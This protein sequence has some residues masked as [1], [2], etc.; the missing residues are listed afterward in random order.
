MSFV[1]DYLEHTKTYESPTSFWKWSAYATIAAVMR[2]NVYRK[3]GDSN[4]YPN[5]YVLF[6]AQSGA[7]K[8]APIN[9]AKSLIEAVN[10][11]KVIAGRTSIQAVLDE[12]AHT[13]TNNKTGRL[14]KGGAAI[15]VA[16]ELAAGIVGDPAAISILTD[17]YDLKTDFKHHLR[18]TGR[19]K[20]DRIVFN[21]L[22]ASNA[23]L[24]KEVYTQG[25]VNGGLLGRTFVIVPSEFRPP[26][27][28][29]DAVDNKES[30]EN[31]KAQLKKISELNGEIHI[32]DEARDE[33]NKWY[34]PYYT[35]LKSK[36][37]KSGV[38]S[39]LH[40]GV[41]KLSI[42]LA[43]NDNEMSI[44]RCHMELAITE[45][46]SLIPNYNTFIMTSGKST[47]AEAGALF[48]EEILAAPDYTI[49]TKNF[50]QKHWSN[51]DSDLLSKLV[52]TLET[53]GL[54]QSIASGGQMSFKLT[55]KAIET[56]EAKGRGKE[57]K[58]GV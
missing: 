55:N 31:L 34:K 56:M 33:Y 7:R 11:T 22:A 44:R 14:I 6:L 40:M 53:A 54:V 30:H 57:Q 48:F 29:L 51:V 18:S 4:T 20:I 15:L 43:A 49:S 16:G 21:M 17:I 10:N 24:L 3:Q 41:F 25:A 42:I 52:L 50:L 47:Q 2:D 26:N 23:D 28:L 13:E 36:G 58:G 39:R 37:D 35:S 5:I 38:L 19:F 27:S 32:S 8:G 1:S 12:L 9:L 45:C 46:L